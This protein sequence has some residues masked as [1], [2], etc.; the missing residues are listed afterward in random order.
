MR[1]PRARHAVSPLRVRTVTTLTLVRLPDCPHGPAGHVMGS[2]AVVI[3]NRSLVLGHRP[4]VEVM[5]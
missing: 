3:H 2:L 5:Y 1:P 4:S